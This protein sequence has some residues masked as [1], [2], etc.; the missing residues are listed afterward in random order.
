LSGRECARDEPVPKPPFA[1]SAACPRHGFEVRLAAGI[2]C[3]C[4]RELH[5]YD[6]EVDGLR[7][8]AICRGSDQDVLIIERER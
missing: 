1:R 7:V 2:R 3:R 8:H 4:G 5:A 6:F